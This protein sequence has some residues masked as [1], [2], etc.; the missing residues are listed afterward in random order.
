M[1][2]DQQTASD[3]LL[4]GCLAFAG[5]SAIEHKTSANYGRAK[6]SSFK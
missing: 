5:I 6:P 3:S 1:E 2:K 4:D